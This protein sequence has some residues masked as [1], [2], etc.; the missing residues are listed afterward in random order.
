[1]TWGRDVL[2]ADFQP[3]RGRLKSIHRSLAHWLQDM[4]VFMQKKTQR[5]THPQLTMR[6]E[7]FTEAW[8]HQLLTDI[9]LVL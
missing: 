8:G 1:M 7:L 2:T 9:N 3:E 5:Q 4:L 6:L